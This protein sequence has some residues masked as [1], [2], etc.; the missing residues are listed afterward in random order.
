MDAF[1][2]H[3]KMFI[4]YRNSSIQ[5]WSKWG[6]EYYTCIKL[7]NELKWRYAVET[8]RIYIIFNG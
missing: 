7:Q 2:A 3:K 8:V 5:I 4:W 1:Y 6:Q